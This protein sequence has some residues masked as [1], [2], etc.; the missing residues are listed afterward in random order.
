MGL[1]RTPFAAASGQ[2]LPVGLHFAIRRLLCCYDATSRCGSRQFIGALNA[3]WG[4]PVEAVHGSHR[5][6]PRSPCYVE[7]VYIPTT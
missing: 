1:Q 6:I 5:V 2:R 7:H 3:A 4:R